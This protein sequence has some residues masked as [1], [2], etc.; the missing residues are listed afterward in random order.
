MLSLQEIALLFIKD[1]PRLTLY[2]VN[3]PF[4]LAERIFEFLDIR[5][6]GIREEDIQLFNSGKLKMENIILNGCRIEKPSTLSFMK[7]FRLKTLRVNHIIKF[8]LCDW[9]KYASESDLIELSLIKCSLTVRRR[10]L[11]DKPTKAIK[12]ISKFS[13]LK[14]LQIVST[15]FNDACLKIICNKLTFLE[16]LNIS[17]TAVKTLKHIPKLMRLISIDFSSLKNG[18]SYNEVNHLKKLLELKKIEF[19]KNLLWKSNF[20]IEWFRDIFRNVYWKGLEVF[21]LS[22][23]S[24]IDEKSVK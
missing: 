22:G 13:S 20:D 6:Y 5:N 15:N 19:S 1:N 12:L 10:L 14:K 9:L 18:I 8:Q 24:Q 16:D 21:S 11:E 17:K 23:T 7:N 2:K 4:Y 3:I